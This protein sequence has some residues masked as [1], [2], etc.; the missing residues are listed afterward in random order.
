[1]TTNGK[2]GNQW[3]LRHRFWRRGGNINSQENLHIDTITFLIVLQQEVE[4]S[5][6]TENVRVHFSLCFQDEGLIAA[7]SLNER[8]IAV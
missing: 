5:Q 1:M 3:I 8:T 7:N 6:L 2:I 4:V